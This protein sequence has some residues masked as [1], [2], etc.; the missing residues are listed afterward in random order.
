MR[1]VTVYRVDYVEKTKVPIGWVMERRRA[2][3]STNYL[4]LLRL[5]RRLYASSVQDGFYIAIDRK[6]V[7]RA[8]ARPPART[9]NRSLR[10]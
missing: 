10:A 1:A 6:E 2:A 7:D 4:G 5:A 8:W 9:E 3:R